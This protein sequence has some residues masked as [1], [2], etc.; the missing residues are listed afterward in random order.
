MLEDLWQDTRYS[1]RLLR[2]N[3]GFTAVAALTLALGIG[4]NS[5]IFSVVNVVLRPLSFPGG[6]RLVDIREYQQKVDLNGMVNRDFRVVLEQNRVLEQ[7]SAYSWGKYTLTGRVQPEELRGQFITS[8]FLPMLGAQPAHGRAFSAEEFKKGHRPVALISHR[9]WQRKFGGDA[10]LIGQELI[11]NGESHTVI[12]VMPPQFRFISLIVSSAEEADLWL[13]LVVPG[14][15]LENLGVIGRLKSGMTIDQATRELNAITSKLEPLFWTFKGGPSVQLTPL[16]E[17]GVKDFRQ[18]LLL[19]WGAIGFVLL[20]ACTNVTNLLLARAVSRHKEI[21]I[22]ASLGAGRRRI[23]QQLLTDSLLLALLGGAAGLVLS[24]WG[25]KLLI[26]ISP[27][28]IPRLNQAEVSLEVAAYTFLVSLFTG[29]LC[30]LTPALRL[31]NPDLI[32]ALKEGAMVSPAGFRLPSWLRLPER[33]ASVTGLSIKGLAKEVAKTTSSRFSSQLNIRSLLVVAE[34][35]VA[36]VLLMGAGLMLRSF[37]KLL[38]VNPGFE[39]ER[40]LTMDLELPLAKYPKREQVNDFIT[41]IVVAIEGLP[42]VQAAGVATHLP[43]RGLRGINI[44]YVQLDGRDAPSDTYKGDIPPG[45]LNIPPPPSGPSGNSGQNADSSSQAVSV[46]NANVSPSYFRAMGIPIQRGREFNESDNLGAPRVAIVSETMARRF[47]PGE[48]PIGKRFRFRALPIEWITVVGVAGNI[49]HYTLETEARQ[50]MYQSVLQT[51]FDRNLQG[52]S[53]ARFSLVV[54]TGGQPTDLAA[55]VC[56][57]VWRLNPDQPIERLM[58]MATVYKEAVAPRRFNM[59]MFSAFAG[60]ALLLAAIGIYGVVSYTVTQRTREIGVRRAL[61]AHN[62]DVLRLIVGHGLLL[63]LIGV[64]LGLAGA[65][66]LSRLLTS[67]LFGVSA[68]DSMTFAVVGAMFIFIA[69]L[70]CYL[71][72]RRAMKIDPVVALRNE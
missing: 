10:N 56:N 68:T 59:H 20:I 41:Q 7:M 15:K 6:D 33:K 3:K 21:A 48:D 69:L 70:A 11:L 36:V 53:A 42:G 51:N 32:G 60:V 18:K 44:N 22:R 16:H 62:N 50:A 34:I 30:G 31:S 72:A 8:D 46:I 58:P 2:K 65:F 13:P 12:G 64:A 43:L 40:R 1:L 24:Y 27:T 4:A 67:L 39:P 47:W 37:Q 14:D 61:G 28:T 52:N 19:F 9:L 45:I 54:R 5:V 63:T 66:T 25:L 71:P 17:L 57:Q 38:A 49:R 26:S 23:V 35:A 29:A 55:E